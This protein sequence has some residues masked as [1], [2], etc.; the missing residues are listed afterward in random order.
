MCEVGTW[1]RRASDSTVARSS[2]ES[3]ILSESVRAGWRVGKLSGVGWLLIL[4]LGLS[5]KLTDDLAYGKLEARKRVSEGSASSRKILENRLS[6][7]FPN[8]FC[9]GK[10][11]HDP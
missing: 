5:R 8:F 11:A 9:V 1:S 6:E 2:G 4:G 3:R 10:M 7:D